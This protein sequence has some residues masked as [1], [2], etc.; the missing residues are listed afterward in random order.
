MLTSVSKEKPAIIGLKRV[1]PVYVGHCWLHS[2]PPQLIQM[3]NL[4]KLLDTMKIELCT[5]ISADVSFRVQRYV[6]KSEVRYITL[7]MIRDFQYNNET[8]VARSLQ[9]IVYTCG[10][11]WRLGGQ[12]VVLLMNE[13]QLWEVANITGVILFGT[14]IQNLATQATRHPW[15]NHSPIPHIFQ[16]CTNSAFQT[17]ASFLK[18]LQEIT[19]T[20]LELLTVFKIL[21]SH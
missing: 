4:R 6:V 12:Q 15:N 7:L 11:G 1:K 3:T 16:Q 13:D 9:S 19:D 20:M 2:K 8:A 5:I 17:Q 21:V 14:T 10:K 18:P